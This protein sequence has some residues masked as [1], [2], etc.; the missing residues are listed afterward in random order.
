MTDPTDEEPGALARP[1]PGDAANVDRDWT[2]LF[3]AWL[4][5]S[6]ATL[7]S[8]FFSEVMELPPC[9]LCWVQRVFM[10]PLAVILLFGLFPFDRGVVRYALPLALTGAVVALYHQLVQSG[11]IPESAAPC[12]QGVSCSEAQLALL[13]FVSIPMLSLAVFATVSGLLVWL[14][15]RGSP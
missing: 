10:F 5:V 12:R 7:G 15:R 9:S 3:F 4:L 14:K 2:I 11:W 6:G 13:G 1:R 8:L